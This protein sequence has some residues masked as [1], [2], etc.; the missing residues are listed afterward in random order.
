MTSR[1]WLVILA[2]LF[3]C[4]E[5]YLP[6]DDGDDGDPST[7]PP[8][9]GGNEESFFPLDS[10]I[11]QEGAEAALRLA[12]RAT[13]DELSSA[14]Q[15]GLEA[16]VAASIEGYRL[17][18]DGKFG[19]DDDRTIDDL[20]EL[21]AIP[22]V[23]RD[24]FYR[25][26]LYADAEGFRTVPACNATS[27]RPVR[28]TLYTTP[29][30]GQT[31]I[32]D[33][34][35]SARRSVDL[36]MYQLRSSVIITA[37]EDAAARGVRVRVILDRQQDDNPGLVTKLTA[38]GAQAK[39]SSQSFIY[40]H[41]K[42]LI[43]D[44]RKSLVS[45]GNFSGD[46]GRDYG[47]IGRDWQDVDDLL[48]LFEADWQNRAPDVSC[49]RLV[50]SPVNSRSR[51]IE[52]IDAAR[53]SLD[54][55]AL[56][57]TDTRVIDAIKAAKARGVAVRVLI[58]DPA[59]GFSDGVAV[60]DLA[61]LGIESRHSQRPFFIHAKTLIADG[62]TVFIGSENFSANSLDNNRECGEVMSDK[63]F[64]VPRLRTLFENDWARSV[65]F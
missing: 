19:T 40:T 13:L 48:E 24:A 12:N 4:R 46:T 45:S 11:T 18:A 36:V 6:P 14:T 35:K 38:R 65:S 32:V 62:T 22:G 28:A 42:T 3:A 2:A 59:F 8:A 1:W 21:D 47:V 34:I 52:V 16:R 33:L 39:L 10:R 60:R 51:V 61:A 27:P 29:D 54:I 49:T 25:L 43:I 63:D 20:N 64:D 44:R 17:G 5:H 9:G 23:G 15:G 31:P 37:L 26:V 57:V 56:Y 53:S 30:D 55:E 41:Q 50:V 7:M 58:N